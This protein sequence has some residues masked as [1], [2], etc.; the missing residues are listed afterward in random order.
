M[1][2]GLHHGLL[3]NSDDRRENDGSPLSVLP[4][5]LGR[6]HPEYPHERSDAGEAADTQGPIVKWG[7]GL[8]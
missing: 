7:K 3:G 1:Q 5:D 2:R 4:E 6:L 8:S